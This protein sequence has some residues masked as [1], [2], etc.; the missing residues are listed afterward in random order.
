M[1]GGFFF[2][3]SPLATRNSPLS[4]SSRFPSRSARP[5]RRRQNSLRNFRG[6][7]PDRRF[8]IAPR[9]SKFPSHA[10]FRCTNFGSPF[11]SCLF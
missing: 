10:L 2:S 4:L 7:L 5:R 9:R 11:A 6:K 1:R 3:H 8:Q